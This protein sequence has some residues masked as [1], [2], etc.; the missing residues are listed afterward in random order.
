MFYKK[1]LLILVIIV[2]FL[3]LTFFVVYLITKFKPGPE[4]V[5]QPEP[6]PI[7]EL[8]KEEIIQGLTAP[9]EV[10]PKPLSE[11]VFK[12]LSAP[13]KSAIEPMPAPQEILDS[14]TAP[15]AK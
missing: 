8:T 2:S 6:A 1:Q 13:Q 15:A 12:N 4:S 5:G 14:L 10:N 3:I 7:K 9:A 11:E